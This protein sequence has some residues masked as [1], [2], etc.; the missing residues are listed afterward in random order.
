MDF[1]KGIPTDKHVSHEEIVETMN[2]CCLCGTGLEFTHVTH[3][4]M[5][6]VQEAAKC[7]S[8][9]IQTKVNTFILQ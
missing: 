4:E 9:G 3:A 1:Q 5:H 7:P 6:R 8:C 2:T